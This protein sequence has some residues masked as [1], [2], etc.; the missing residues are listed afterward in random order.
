M[1]PLT[2][3]IYIPYFLHSISLRLVISNMKTTIK[4]VIQCDDKE[5]N[6]N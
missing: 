2:Y 4:I 1:F 6:K 5:K 3:S